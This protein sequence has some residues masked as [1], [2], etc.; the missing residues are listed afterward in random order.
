MEISLR[1]V[2]V[3]LLNCGIHE[4][5]LLGSSQIRREIQTIIDAFNREDIQ[6]A[7][8]CLEEH[9]DGVAPKTMEDAEILNVLRPAY[10]ACE[11]LLKQKRLYPYPLL[12][13]PSKN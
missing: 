4:Q 13:E 2:A 8:R 12:P 10:F 6:A 1:E 3:A 7:D 9:T 11:R 5:V